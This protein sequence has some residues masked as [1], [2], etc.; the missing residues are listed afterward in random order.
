[1]PK[2]KT[3]QDY[4]VSGLRFRVIVPLKPIEY[5]FGHIIIRSHIPHILST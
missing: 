1:M 3:L 4:R 5:G 2:S